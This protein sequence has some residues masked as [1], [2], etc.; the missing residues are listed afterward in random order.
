VH[1]GAA[2]LSL[3]PAMAR[4][5]GIFT[6][7][8]AKGRKLTADRPIIDCIDREQKE[9]SPSGTVVRKIGPS[10]TAKERAAEDERARKAAEERNRLAEE[11]R[12][13]RALLNRYP[14]QKAHEKERMTALATAD[15]VI[16]AANRRLLELDGERTRLAQELEFY[17]GD[18]SKAPHA[19]R[20]HAEE[21]E[22]Q[23][24]AQKRFIANQQD[25]K[26]RITA[27]YD[28]E[29]GRLKSLWAQHAAAQPAA[30]N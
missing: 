30:Q 9:I 10:L 29:L 21:I 14:D 19:M 28:E 6:C 3:A 26:K 16:A 13:D 11:K 17:K 15:G 5:Q 25:E 1:L 24:Q 22:Q 27:R 20:R 4:A 23:A 12:R 7:I 2:F 18:L 8:D